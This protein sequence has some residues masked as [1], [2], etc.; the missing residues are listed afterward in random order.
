MNIQMAEEREI[1]CFPEQCD[2]GY[3]QTE[4]PQQFV[5][6]KHGQPK[7]H[8]FMSHCGQ[9]MLKGW[10]VTYWVCKKCGRKRKGYWGTTAICSL[11]NKR[12]CT[13]SPYG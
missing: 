7:R 3:D 6:N 10:I 2:D 8:L 4:Y 11:C 1:T 9:R 5:L 12:V 13:G